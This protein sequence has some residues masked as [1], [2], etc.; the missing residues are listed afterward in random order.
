VLFASFV[1][2][3]FFVVVE[4]ALAIAFGVLGGKGASKRN[5]AAVLEWGTYS[6]RDGQR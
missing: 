5:A 2:K 3:A 1:I 4:I 6:S